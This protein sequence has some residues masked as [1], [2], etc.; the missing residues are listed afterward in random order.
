MNDPQ[1]NA[2]RDNLRITYDKYA[3][4]RDSSKPQDWKVRERAVFLD[5]LKQEQKR[6]LLEIGAGTGRDGKFLQEQG[7][8]VTCIDLSPVMV[9]LCKQ[10]GL[11][12]YVMDMTD[13]RLD[14]APF[15]AVYAIN[16]L[17][18]LPKAEFLPV[19]RQIEGVLRPGGLF[20]LGV[21]GGQDFEGVWEKDFYDPKRFFSFFTDAAIQQEVKKVFDLVSFL[22]VPSGDGDDLHFQ[23]MILRKR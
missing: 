6:T 10:K 11:N 9:E 23:S 14:E 12:A 8:D 20:F 15:D 5:L 1:E 13:L 3:Q 4:E 22:A 16:S 21:Y 2:A 7:F 18:H 19:L 17:L